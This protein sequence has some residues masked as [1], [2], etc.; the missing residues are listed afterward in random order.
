MNAMRVLEERGD[1]AQAVAVAA[2]SVQKH[3]VMGRRL[4]D[5]FIDQ[6]GS[7]VLEALDVDES[8]SQGEGGSVSRRYCVSE[9]GSRVADGHREAQTLVGRQGTNLDACARAIDRAVLDH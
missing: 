6:A 9:C 5:H 8:T 1:A 3:Q 2:P 7:V 4:S